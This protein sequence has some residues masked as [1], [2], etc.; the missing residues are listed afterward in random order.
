MNRVLFSREEILH[1][2]PLADARAQHVLNVLRRTPGDTFDAGL[3]D[4]PAGKAKL[5]AVEPAHLVL[6]FTWGHVPPALPPVH[7]I[8]GLPRPQTARKLL[9]ELTSLGVS[10]I[11]FVTTDRG[12]PGYAQST[13]W[14]SGEWRR[15]VIAGVEQAFC[16]RLP[17]ISWNRTLEE[18]LAATTLPGR[19]LVV[20]DNYESPQPLGDVAL[21]SPVT[22]V[23]GSERGWTGRERLLLK[24]TGALFAHLGTRVLR[25][26][27]A[28]VAAVAVIHSRLGHWHP[29]S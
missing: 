9:N 15:H 28:L 2:L 29:S 8:V 19:S 20:L 10:C 5:E 6:S 3:L 25:T 4:G 17:E 24:D 23:A 12:E 27:T 7:C 16:T 21:H 13:L 22:L 1:P 26:E 18:A 11:H 14:S